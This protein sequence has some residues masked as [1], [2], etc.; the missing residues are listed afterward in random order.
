M[1]SASFETTSDGFADIVEG[2]GFCA[3]LRNATWDRRTLRNEH[4]GFV[5]FQRHE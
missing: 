5:G 2:L 3:S 1:S 4:T